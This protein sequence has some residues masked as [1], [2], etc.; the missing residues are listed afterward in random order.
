MTEVYLLNLYP[1]TVTVRV[2]EYAK[3]YEGTKESGITTPQAFQLKLSEH[4]IVNLLNTNFIPTSLEYKAV[5]PRMKFPHFSNY[6]GIMVEAQGREA[7]STVHVPSSVPFFTI[8][9]TQGSDGYPQIQTSNS[10]PQVVLNEIA[11]TSSTTSSQ[12][13]TT[14]STS[15]TTSSSA[16]QSST[17][18]TTTTTPLSSTT[19]SS[20]SSTS[21]LIDELFNI[22]DLPTFQNYIDYAYLEISYLLKGSGSIANLRSYL[23][24]IYDGLQKAIN[25]QNQAG[26]HFAIVD[27][28]CQIYKNLKTICEELSNGTLTVS[29]LQSLRMPSDIYAN[30]SS[31]Y[32]RAIAQQCVDDYCK[33]LNYFISLLS[34]TQS[35]TTSSTSSTTTPPNPTSSSSSSATSSSGT[36]VSSSSPTTISQGQILAQIQAGDINSLQSEMSELP[37]NMVPVVSAVIQLYQTY[38]IPDGTPLSTAVERLLSDIRDAYYKISNHKQELVNT[39]QLSKLLQIYKTLASNGLAPASE[40]ASKLSKLVQTS[41]VM[42]ALPAVLGQSYPGSVYNNNVNS[43]LV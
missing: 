11:R 24:Q 28:W 43:N 37:S 25:F 5:Y 22:I 26:V 1:G 10:P 20:S 34:S 18:P 15:S 4:Q 13:S 32:E 27:V 33:N 16:T 3:E 2:V 8:Y 12:S 38:D 21:S 17:P 42:P 39:Q 36:T 7:I 29:S 14:S 19:S 9:I 35:S 40:S 6:I 41:G 23:Q 30:A 31:S